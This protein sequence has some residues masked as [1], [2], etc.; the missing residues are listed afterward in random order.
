[1]KLNKLESLDNLPRAVL[2]GKLVCVLVGGSFVDWA[3]KEA[4]TKREEPIFRRCT[5]GLIKTPDDLRGF[6]DDKC[7]GVALM[8]CSKS[9]DEGSALQRIV[10]NWSLTEF[11]PIKR[12]GIRRVLFASAEHSGEFEDQITGDL[13]GQR[14]LAILRTRILGRDAN[15]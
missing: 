8:I 12:G 4:G 2:L 6:L 14:P 3:I 9:S 1:M 13:Y 15:D 5:N 11:T 7:R 10:S